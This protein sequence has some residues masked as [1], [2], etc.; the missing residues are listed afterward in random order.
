MDAT[1]T[2]KQ[3]KSYFSYKLSVSVDLEHGFIHRI[4]MGMASEHDGHYFDEVLDM[5][6]SGRTYGQGVP[7]AARGGKCSRRWAS[8]TRC[9]ARRGRACH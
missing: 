4:C 9:S 5:H 6:N 7:R 8:W 3:G 2:E 1:H